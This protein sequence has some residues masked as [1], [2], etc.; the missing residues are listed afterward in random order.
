MLWFRQAA[1]PR[2]V[3]RTRLRLESLGDRAVP[4]GLDE[5][6]LLF[7]PVGALGGDS[8]TIAVA[9]QIVDFAGVGI[10]PGWFQFTGRVTGPATLGGLVI[11]FGGV[12]SL[13]GVTTTTAA[14]GTFSLTISVRTDG[15]DAGTVTAQTVANGLPSNEALC[16]ID[17]AA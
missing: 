14:D 15:T 8:T 9:P 4:S 1:R 17:P 13:Q 12:P 3:L 11:T 5:P 7:A 10:S 16:N 6:P 2:P